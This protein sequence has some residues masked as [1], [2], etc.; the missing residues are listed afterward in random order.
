M[1]ITNNDKGSKQDEPGMTNRAWPG[2]SGC[3]VC[4]YL[5]IQAS[6]IMHA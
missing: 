2:K 6:K 3:L 5:R 1:L 4:P